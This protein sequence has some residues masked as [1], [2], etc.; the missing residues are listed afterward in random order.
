MVWCNKKKIIFIHIPKTGGS[1]IECKLGLN[2]PKNGFK[3]AKYNNKDKAF[4]HFTWEQYNSKLLPEKFNLYFK[5]SVCRN[6]YTRII[7]EYYWCEA[8]G[9]GYKND[10]NIDDFLSSVENIVSNESYDITIYHDHFIPQH[11]FIFDDNKELKIDQFF[12]F[13]EFNNIDINLKKYY[14]DKEQKI[15]KKQTNIKNKIELTPEQKEKVYKIY[16]NDFIL[17]KY[18]K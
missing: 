7:S 13:E 9:L 15:D 10:Q 3:K 18:D 5:F 12:Y 1:Y 17:L 16:K 11:M 8:P 14:I 6:P 2:N 4:Q